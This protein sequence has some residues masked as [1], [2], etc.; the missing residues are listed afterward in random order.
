[1]LFLQRI[2]L[3]THARRRSQSRQRPPAAGQRGWRDW[4][5]VTG[6]AGVEWTHCQSCWRPQTLWLTAGK[7]A[8]L[9][10]PAGLPSPQ[11]GWKESTDPMRS[12]QLSPANTLYLTDLNQYNTTASIS[13]SVFLMNMQIFAI[14]VPLVQCSFM[15]EGFYLE[16]FIS[17]HLVCIP[18]SC[19]ES[20]QRILLQQLQTH[21]KLVSVSSNIPLDSLLC[22]N[23]AQISHVSSSKG[24][25]AFWMMETAPGGIDSGYCTSSL[26]MLS[27]TSSSS[28]PGNGD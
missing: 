11:S 5:E 3:F 15:R 6:P 1:M 20:F 21:S 18:L 28:S 27:N 16:E 8:L 26:T 17:F 10:W 12:V 14:Q 4:L 9:S 2:A 24:T 22:L 25:L 19:S 7:A 23:S 13:N